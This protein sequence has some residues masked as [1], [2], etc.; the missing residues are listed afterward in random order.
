MIF[1]HRVQ[2]EASLPPFEGTESLQEQQ[3]QQKKTKRTVENKKTK[4]KVAVHLNASQ[5][6]VQCARTPS[7][8]GSWC[9]CPFVCSEE[10]RA[11]SLEH[12]LQHGRGVGGSRLPV[13]DGAAEVLD[14][15]AALP[16]LLELPGKDLGAPLPG[17]AR[18]L[19][20]QL[21]HLH[22]VLS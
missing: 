10:P 22:V 9:I 17:Q 16:D 13:L 5:N 12:A 19:Q 6:L 8:L 21:A 3:R 15:A 4:T 1:L 14:P 18:L 7:V 20:T 2:R 11:A